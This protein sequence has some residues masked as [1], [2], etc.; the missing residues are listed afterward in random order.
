MSSSDS[1]RR[2]VPYWRA[3]LTGRWAISLRA[4]ILI[5]LLMQWPSYVRNSVP[6]NLPPTWAVAIGI[7]RILAAGLV[8]LI[9]DRTYLRRR[10]SEPA[11]LT[12]VIATWIAAGAAAMAV[13]WA[14]WLEP[15]EIAVV[16]RTT[17]DERW[18]AFLL[19]AQELLASRGI[20]VEIDREDERP[21]RARAA[22]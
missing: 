1:Q 11:S 19:G 12:V 8:L 4:W 22:R 13:Q 17:L 20:A 14:A 15:A 7:L 21:R 5:S 18:P 2:A 6:S 3:L 10:A 9:A 16:G